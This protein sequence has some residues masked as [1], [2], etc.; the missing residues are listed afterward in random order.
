MSARNR[1]QH[2]NLP[3]P[4]YDDN[5]DVKDIEQIVD[6]L[7]EELNTIKQVA[8]H[9]VQM[10]E[11][12]RQ[13]V[14]AEQGRV[15][16]E[17]TRVGSERTRVQN[18]QTRT[19]AESLRLRKEEERVQNES[20]RNSAESQRQQK[21]SERVTREEQRTRVYN[22]Q[23]A[24][25]P[26]WQQSE[27]NRKSAETRRIKA[28][29]NRESNERGRVSAEQE[30]VRA[31]ET[32]RNAETTRVN[33]YTAF[34]RQFN[35]FST[36]ETER[37]NNEQARVRAE[38]QRARQYASDHERATQN[39]AKTEAMLDNIKRLETG[40]LIA[41]VA[42]IQTTFASKTY[43]NDLIEKLIGG[44]DDSLDTLKELADVLT[45]QGGSI[46]SILTQLATKIPKEEATRLFSNLENKLTNL[47]NTKGDTSDLVGQISTKVSTSTFDEFKRTTEASL[48][49][50]ASTSDLSRI[51][52]EVGQ[53]LQATLNSKVDKVSGKGLSTN[54]YTTAE[55]QKL[56]SLSAPIN[57]LT[58]TS[59]TAPL[60]AAQGKELKRLI[61]SKPNTPVVDSLTSTSTTS[62]LSA[63]QGKILDGRLRVV[64][65]KLSGG[66]AT[67]GVDSTEVNAVKA[68]TNVQLLNRLFAKTKN[69]GA[70]LAESA[71][72]QG[73]QLATCQSLV[74]VLNNQVAVNLLFN[75][76]MLTKAFFASDTA[77]LALL[78]NE[79]LA[80]KVF[81][82]AIAMEKISKSYP[83]LRLIFKNEL[84]R[85]PFVTSSKVRENMFNIYNSVYD[86]GGWEFTKGLH[87]ETSPSYPNGKFQTTHISLFGCGGYSDS[88]DRQG[89]GLVEYPKKGV[90]NLGIKVYSKTMA[91]NYK[92]RISSSDLNSERWLNLVTVGCKGLKVIGCAEN[93]T[94]TTPRKERYGTSI[95]ST[96]IIMLYHEL[97]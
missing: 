10:A 85:I 32:R 22:E 86:N 54:D 60:S 66:S 40:E 38:E 34:E 31:E 8:L 58:S 21:E 73:S 57:N 45:T 93:P 39:V 79:A 88:Y 28:E 13:R 68:G 84:A 80:T 41:D 75:N 27:T 16:T 81:E 35:T 36:K 33:G 71:N 59:T 23:S 5:V 92:N 53:G 30:R 76:A 97:V 51:Q 95:T 15:H 29:E 24:K 47:I 19:Q 7:D 9:S 94:S 89:Y 2:L 20:T 52:Q 50:K 74:D 42:E 49:G 70:T 65:G 25:F 62:A 83:T 3:R 1:T 90:V 46:Q 56:A 43:V 91:D 6:T 18:E 44:A 14:S 77:M 12:E 48:A 67:I 26:E 11:A 82:N 78:D 64:E 96:K 87:Y 72:L 37:Q 61:D 55:K 69:V 4:N 17:N 63:N